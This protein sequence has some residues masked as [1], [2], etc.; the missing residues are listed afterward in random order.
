MNKTAKKIEKANGAKPIVK[1]R[2]WYRTEIS[3]CVLCGKQKTYKGR[4]YNEKD[5]GVSYDQFACDIH[6]M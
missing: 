3:E 1:R 2:Y 5:K 4:V 6:F